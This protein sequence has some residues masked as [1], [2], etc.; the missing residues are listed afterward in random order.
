MKIYVCGGSS[1]MDVVAE[2]MR[3]L[4]EMGHII[5]C[6]W[7]EAIRAVGEANPRNASHEQRAAWGTEDL[8]GIEGADL[9]W[10]MLPVSPSLGC[11]FEA[12]FAIRNG[13]AVIVSGDW[14][15]TIFSAQAEAR[16]DEHDQAL[17]WIRLCGT[18]GTHDDAMDALEAI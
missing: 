17:E 4:R 5:T 2:R 8:H 12:G 6:D 14:R 1:E 15:A 11:A 3:Q 18:P 7:V 16:F 13:S 9:V 10:V